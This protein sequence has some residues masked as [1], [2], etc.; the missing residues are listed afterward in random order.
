MPDTPPEVKDGYQTHIWLQKDLNV[1]DSKLIQL[2]EQLDQA[3]LAQ[4]MQMTRVVK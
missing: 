2:A 4:D 1:D 3:R